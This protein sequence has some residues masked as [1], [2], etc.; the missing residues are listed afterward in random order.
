MR[1]TL[2]EVPFNIK[3][4]FCERHIKNIFIDSFSSL[5]LLA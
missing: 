5:G 1:G 2:Y 3:L 4:I